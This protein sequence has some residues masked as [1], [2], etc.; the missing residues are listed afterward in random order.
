[1][2]MKSMKL[3]NKSKLY[4]GKSENVIPILDDDSIDLVITSPPYNVDLGNN[5]FNDS[6]Y[7][8]YNDNKDH[9]DYIAWLKDSEL[10]ATT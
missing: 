5:K 8:R 1:M 4:H 2:K 7:D 10:L 6:P 9:K 3:S